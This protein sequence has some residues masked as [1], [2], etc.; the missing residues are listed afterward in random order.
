PGQGEVYD[1]L[2]GPEYDVSLSDSR[3]VECSDFEYLDD[4]QQYLDDYLWGLLGDDSIDPRFDPN[5]PTGIDPNRDGVVDCSTLYPIPYIRP[6]TDEEAAE[7]LGAVAVQE[8]DE[9]GDATFDLPAGCYYAVIGGLGY[10]TTVEEFCLEPG[11]TEVNEVNMGEAPGYLEKWFVP[12]FCDY[13][14]PGARDIEDIDGLLEDCYRY[15]DWDDVS[16]SVSIFEGSCAEAMETGDDDTAEDLCDGPVYWGGAN[17]LY[18]WEGI[19]YLFVTLAEGNYTLCWYGIW[20]YTTNQD[21]EDYV[22]VTFNCEEFSITSEETTQL[23]NYSDDH[24]AGRI[25]VLVLDEESQPIEGILVLLFDQGGNLLNWECTD[26]DG[27]ADFD[28]PLDIGV[29]GDGNYTV[30]ATDSAPQYGIFAGCGYDDE[31]ETQ[32]AS[33]AYSVFADWDN[34]TFVNDDVSDGYGDPE[35]ILALTAVAP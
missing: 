26:Q 27:E 13:P 15:L 16:M 5:Y 22:Y 8:T 17:D 9:N 20:S 12:P 35:A 29:Y 25:D 2:R 11:E 10:E 31:Y 33:I 18:P 19:P 30:T 21:T 24:A 7:I 6:A 28:T 1:R 14:T 4:A 34:D 3:Y 32:N 23:V